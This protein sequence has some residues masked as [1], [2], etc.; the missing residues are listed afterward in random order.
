MKRMLVPLVL[1][2]SLPVIATGAERDAVS[3]KV[4]EG[5]W[6]RARLFYPTP[7]Q[8]EAEERGK[9]FIYHN[10]KDTE[11]ARA[12]DEHFSR[13]DAMMF[14]GTVITDYRG[15]VLRDGHTGRVVVEDDGCDD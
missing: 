2:A 1:G 13:I 11:V 4:L 10:L 5:D 8:R 14:T 3:P 7:T 6:Q 9:V 12:M 15:M